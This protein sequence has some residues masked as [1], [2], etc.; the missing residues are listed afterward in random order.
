M[1]TFILVSH[2]LFPGHLFIPIHRLDHW[3]CLVGMIFAFNFTRLEAFLKYLDTPDEK[4]RRKR[5]LIRAGTT[6]GLLILF[7]IWFCT[8]LRKPKHSYLAWHAYTSPVP[9]VIYA[10]LRN[11]HPALRTRHVEAFAWLGKITLETYL[12]Q[13]HVYM[14]GDAKKLIVYLPRYP[15]LNF[16]LATCVYIGVSYVL[17]RLTV[18]FSSY[19]LPKVGRSRCRLVE[20]LAIEILI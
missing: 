17:F 8:I 19:L 20:I 18:F 11:I 1:K 10:I 13:I 15:L 14:M 5:Q 6:V 7:A 16:A 9:V 4:S 2:I 3:S 12:S